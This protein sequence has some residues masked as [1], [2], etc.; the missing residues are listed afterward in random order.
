MLIVFVREEYVCQLRLP[1]RKSYPTQRNVLYHK[2][3]A[4]RL[5]NPL[6]GPPLLVDHDPWVFF[7]SAT[8]IITRNFRT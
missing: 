7:L 6:I 2:Y 4:Y 5:Y 8:T 3:Q 1:Y